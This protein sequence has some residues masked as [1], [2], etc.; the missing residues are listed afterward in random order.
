VNKRFVFCA[1]IS[2]Y[3]TVFTAMDVK[4]AINLSSSGSRAV[5]VFFASPY[6]KHSD[7]LTAGMRSR[8]HTRRRTPPAALTYNDHT[9]AKPRATTRGAV[10]RH[11]ASLLSKYYE[12]PWAP[13]ACE[14]ELPRARTR[15]A[16]LRYGCYLC[17]IPCGSCTYSFAYGYLYSFAFNLPIVLF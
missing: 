7:S 4:D 17:R 3:T 16:D 1:L 5:N 11:D 9:L 12:E 13:Y 14:T 8:H 6:H 15:S 2:L 10:P